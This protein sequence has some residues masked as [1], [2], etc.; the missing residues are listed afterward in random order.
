MRRIKISKIANYVIVY[1]FY[2]LILFIFNLIKH[3]P[4]SANIIF[5]PIVLAGFMLTTTSAVTVAILTSFYLLMSAGTLEAE[6]IIGIGIQSLSLILVAVIS[7]GFSNFFKSRAMQEALEKSKLKSLNKVSTNFIT[8]LEPAA[9]YDQ[10]TREIRRIMAADGALLIKLSKNG[11]LKVLAEENGSELGS[12]KSLTALKSLL[13][14]IQSDEVLQISASEYGLNTSFSSIFISPV[15]NNEFV[16]LA[17]RKPRKL[18]N[19]EINLLK[20]FLDD[21]HLALNGAHYYALKEKQARLINMIADL[22]KYVASLSET[23]E[24][25]YASLRKMSEFL[26]SDY[27]VFLVLNDGRLDVISSFEKPGFNLDSRKLHLERLLLSNSFLSFVKT[28]DKPVVASAFESRETLLNEVIKE[29]AFSSAVFLP[30]IINEKIYGAIV[31]FFK[32]EIG[33]EN[34]NSI[35]DSLSA[36]ISMVFYNSRLLAQIKNLTLKTVESIAAAFDAANQY[37]KGH[38][39]RVAKYSTEI[40]K[41]LGLNFKEIR[42]VQYAAFLHDM[43]RIFVN[44]EILNAPRKLTRDELEVVKKIPA[45]SSKIFEKINFFSNIIPIIYHHKEHYD[46]TG[47]PSALKGE[48]I[49]LG[50]RIIHVAESFVAMTSDRPHRPA[51]GIGEAVQEIQRNSG[52]QFDPQVVNALIKVLK[53]EYP[54]LFVDVVV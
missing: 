29:A 34:E 37:T 17:S 9:V 38:S 11:A 44:D 7:G 1:G 4:Y 45:I 12:K 36:E 31:A 50:S 20:N 32:N 28:Q 22:N 16:V 47:Y 52:K 3:I 24:L 39:Q 13:S 15:V 2:A 19:D 10:F 27:S 5:L 51:M 43:G 6:K 18:T 48:E 46:G 49:P 14:K 42:E 8:S 21:A 40:A 30:L 25:I 53:R 41:E 54:T 35:L 33:I 26:G 23:D